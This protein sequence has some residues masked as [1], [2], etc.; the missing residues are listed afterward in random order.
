MAT[1]GLSET[2]VAKLLDLGMDDR[3]RL[4]DT[5][6]KFVDG[7]IY[8]GRPA[9]DDDASGKPLGERRPSV[10]YPGVRNAIESLGDMVFGD[11][12]FPGVTS[13]PSED[14]S[15]FEDDGLSEDDSAVLDHGVSKIIEQSRLR[16]V[17][18]QILAKAQAAGPV[19]IL[20]SVRAAKLRVST[21]DALNCTPEF[22]TVD[23]ERVKSLVVSYRYSTKERDQ[24]D[25]V[26]KHHVYQYRRVID[27]KADTTFAPV[28][29]FRDTQFPVP[30]QVKERVPH[31]LGFC[32]IVW[33]AHAKDES[34]SASR[35]GHPIHWG[36][37]TVIDAINQALSQRH[38][39]A[40]YC[41]DPQV[42]ETGVED[43]DMRMPTAGSTAENAGR[44]TDSTGW[45]SPLN[46]RLGTG[47][48][49]NVQRKKGAGTVWRYTGEGS[50]VM[51]LSLAGDALN[52]LK[53]DG[54]DLKA[55]LRESLSIV[56]LDP[57]VLSGAGDIS[58]KTLAFIFKQQIAAANSLREEVWTGCLLPVLGMLLRVVL[59]V[60][61]G[62]YLPGAKMLRPIL[63]RYVREVEG[64]TDG[65][66][67]DPPLRPVWGQYFE[68]S[69]AD[70]QAKVTTV[71]AAHDG[72][73]ITGES[74]AEKLKPVFKDIK[75][76]TAYVEGVKKYRAEKQQELH[77][78]LGAMGGDDGGDAAGA[79]GAAAQARGTG[80][81]S[82]P[83]A[84]R[85]KGKARP[86]RGAKPAPTAT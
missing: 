63:E 36:L 45:G 56:H 64:Q 24:T 65:V 62:L 38:R 46:T 86:A 10:I 26:L 47:T 37:L 16:I 72:G 2:E 79:S 57:E 19:A 61:T 6:C 40:L 52:V 41:G 54:D 78:A 59:T 70:E 66:W 39:A 85:T 53:E 74:A 80:S 11:Q 58:G 29:I 82:A 25:G 51:L 84:P 67:F 49:S 20:I 34:E 48:T 9:F 7:T 5:H 68:A 77:E 8:D 3:A 31:G 28:E 13:A 32:P 4:I 75:D 15:K 17:A 14:D 30:S 12:G 22:D 71:K 69:D 42:I 23:P 21:I 18:T 27:E 35:D 76:T 33:Y 83:P 81:R 73:L 55:M 1:R 44:T 43:D 60:E 50:K